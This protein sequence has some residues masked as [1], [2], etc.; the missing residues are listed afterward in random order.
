[1]LTLEGVIALGPQF[2]LLYMLINLFKVSFGNREVIMFQCGFVFLL[3][4]TGFVRS[5][6]KLTSIHDLGI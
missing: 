6:L 4:E 1:M 5:P 3:P 2:F